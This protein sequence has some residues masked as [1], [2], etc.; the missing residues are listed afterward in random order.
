VLAALASFG[1]GATEPNQ[2]AAYPN[3]PIRFLVPYAAGGGTDMFAR[4]VGRKLSD[5]TG[6]PVVVDN[7]PGGTGIIAGAAVAKAAPDGY[8]I[9]IDQSSIATNQLFYKKL[10]FDLKRDLAPVVLGARLENAFLVSAQSPVRS[11]ADLV[12]LAKSQPG[13]LA[14]GSAG[15]GS[16]QHLAVELL[17]KQAG[18]DMLHVPYKG[19]P[20]ALMALSADEI[21]LMFFSAAAAEPYIKGGKL[22]AIATTGT[23]RSLVLPDVPT[24]IEA[25]FPDYTNYNWL[26][27][28]TTG[29]TPQPI[30]DALN[31]QLSKVLA[32]PGVRDTLDKQGWGLV[33]GP[34]QTLRRQIDEE[35]ARFEKMIRDG[36]MQMEQP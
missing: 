28:F 15:I 20:P 24:M 17:K 30:V 16:A 10:P 35:T 7:R 22:R 12:K 6:Q 14:Y 31:A 18:I 27:I 4:L 34:P 19:T 8:T 32:D 3:K 25:G 9:L 5:L 26:G 11:M 23:K 2:T 21:Q 1:S 36:G 29:G 13:K 33:G